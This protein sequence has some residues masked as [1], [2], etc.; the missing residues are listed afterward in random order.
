MT[1]SKTTAKA[2]STED[3]EA[4]KLTKLTH[5]DIAAGLEATH[6]SYSDDELQELMAA[7]EELEIP[8]GS[9]KLSSQDFDGICKAI[10]RI[11]D[12]ATLD[13]DSCYDFACCPNCCDVVEA[14]NDLLEQGGIAFS[15]FIGGS[16]DSDIAYGIEALLSSD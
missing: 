2:K 12:A 1:K 14:V 9:E 16:A 13:D 15:D 6:D 10:V 3:D 5:S 7:L 8:K 11:K 4:I